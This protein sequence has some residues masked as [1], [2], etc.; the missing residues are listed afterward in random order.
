[1]RAFSTFRILPRMGRMAWKRRSR[2]CLAEPPA[3]SPSTMYSSHSSGL[4]HAQSASLP[5]S[6]PPSRMVLRRAR[7][8]ALRAASRARAAAIIFST[9][10]RATDGFS[11]KCSRRPSPTTVSTAPLISLLPSLVLVWP[12]NCGFCILMEMTATSPS[13]TSSPP[14]SVLTFLVWPS[15]LA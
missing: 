9:I 3:E 13:R 6:E 5:G 4:S 14:M 12:S 2:P 1:M 7:S 15:L 8:R 10:L 11:S